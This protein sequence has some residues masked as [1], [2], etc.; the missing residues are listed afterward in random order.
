MLPKKANCVYTTLSAYL[1]LP[2]T[3]ALSMKRGMPNKIAQ[4]PKGVCR[5]K[6]SPATTMSEN[7]NPASQHFNK[8]IGFVSVPAFG[9]KRILAIC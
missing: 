1:W 2:V 9:F 6:A 3:M 8:C 7:A 4:N 5:A